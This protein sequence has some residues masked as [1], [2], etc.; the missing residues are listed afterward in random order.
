MPQITASLVDQNNHSIPGGIATWKITTT[1]QYIYKNT[2]PPLF[3]YGTPY[4]TT[5]IA[6]TANPDA[7]LASDAVWTASFPSIV[8][9]DAKLYW[10]YQA[11]G[12]APLI[13]GSFTFRICGTNPDKATG[14]VPSMSSRI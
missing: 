5:A 4:H 8:G 10:T 12:S 6:T 7:Q 1:Y 2:I 11:P 3:G 13:S 14:P 9:G